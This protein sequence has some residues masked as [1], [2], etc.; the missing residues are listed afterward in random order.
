M[1]TVAPVRL[2]ATGQSLFWACYSGAGVF[3]GNLWTG[4]WYE[5]TSIQFA[6]LVD[7]IILALLIMLPVMMLKLGKVPRPHAMLPEEITS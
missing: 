6:V 3:A 7:A 4:Y 1:N 2:R 5:R